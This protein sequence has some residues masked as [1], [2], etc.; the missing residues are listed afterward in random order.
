[1]NP[2]HLQVLEA[3]KFFPLELI[4][5]CESPLNNLET[6]LREL[7]VSLAAQSSLLKYASTTLGD[8]C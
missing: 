4:F 1:M 2:R 5:F 6:F 8:I 7:F 3:K